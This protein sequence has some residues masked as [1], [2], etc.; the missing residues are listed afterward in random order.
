MIDGNHDIGYGRSPQRNQQHDSSTP[1]NDD[2]SHAML[3]RC[4]I[5]F[6]VRLMLEM[7]LMKARDS[8]SYPTVPPQ[9][10]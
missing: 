4:L 10:K 3:V 1:N 9:F 2:N 6:D 8:V 7:V 5:L